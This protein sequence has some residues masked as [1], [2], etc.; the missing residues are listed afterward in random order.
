MNDRDADK[1]F[2][3]LGKSPWLLEDCS[4]FVRFRT[5]HVHRVDVTWP[6]AEEPFTR[7]ARSQHRPRKHLPMFVRSLDQ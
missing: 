6:V 3:H 2:L 7:Q 1:P 4:C 5:V